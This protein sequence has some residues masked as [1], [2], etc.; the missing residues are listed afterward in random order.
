MAELLRWLSRTPAR[1][2]VQAVRE[3]D[4]VRV[5]LE[6]QFE[7]PSLR[8]GGREERFAP[9]GPLRFEARLS[10]EAVGQAVVLENDLALLRLELPTL[11]EWRLE[12]GQAVLRRLS[13]ASGGRLLQD[14][15]ELQ[16]LSDFKA[17]SLQLPLIALA[18]GL[19]LLERLLERRRGIGMR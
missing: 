16:G 18:I 1:P 15:S 11:P 2:R 12:D 9:T 14:V 17:Y 7:R 3:Q 13:E 8:V 6:G 5:L 4:Q 19:F 10:R